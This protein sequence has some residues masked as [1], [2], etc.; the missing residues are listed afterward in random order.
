MLVK[1]EVERVYWDGITIV[2]ALHGSPVNEVEKVKW[3]VKDD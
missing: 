3:T 1:R 2:E